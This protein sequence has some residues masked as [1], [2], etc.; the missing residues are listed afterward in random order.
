VLLCRRG[1][2]RAI[3]QESRAFSEGVG[4]SRNEFQNPAEGL[5]LL[6][7]RVRMGGPKEVRLGDTKPIACRTRGKKDARDMTG[8]VPDH[9]DGSITGTR[10]PRSAPFR[11]DL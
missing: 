11:T 7:R 8:C 5:L 10:E 4:V 3:D 9:P 1:A 2:V 6:L